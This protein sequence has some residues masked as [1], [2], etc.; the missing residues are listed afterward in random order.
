MIQIRHQM[1]KKAAV[2]ATPYP[3]IPFPHKWGQ[4]K[5]THRVSSVVMGFFLPPLVCW[6]G[7]RGADFSHSVFGIQPILN[8]VFAVIPL[9]AVGL[10]LFDR[11]AEV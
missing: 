1:L 6:L 7:L 5:Q 4:G 9:L 2:F 8:G 10:Y 3:S 11:Y